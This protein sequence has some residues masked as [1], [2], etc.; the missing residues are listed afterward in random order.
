MYLTLKNI[1]KIFPHAAASGEVTA[2]KDVSLEIK[3]G[4]LVTLLGPSRLWKNDHVEDDRRFR[5]SQP[6]A[7]S[8]W[9]AGDQRP[10]ATQA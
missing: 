2:V 8:S 5:I 7:R 4:E 1:T 10:A 6:A 9:M 3:K